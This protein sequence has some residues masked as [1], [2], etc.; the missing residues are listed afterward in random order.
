MKKSPVALLL[1]IDA[2]GITTI[3][4]LLANYGRK[5]SLPNLSRLGLGERVRAPLADAARVEIVV[6]APPAAD[7]RAVERAPRTRAGHTL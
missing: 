1:V 7:V 5:V 4:H 3:E 2:V 6:A